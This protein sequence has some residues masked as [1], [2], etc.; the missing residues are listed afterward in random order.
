MN[1]KRELIN[2]VKSSVR[3]Y[4]QGSNFTKQIRFVRIILENVSMLGGGGYK[5]TKW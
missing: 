5:G 3:N 1:Y 4:S 2:I